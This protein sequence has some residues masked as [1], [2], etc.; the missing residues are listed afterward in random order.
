MRAQLKKRD[1]ALGV[2][3][4]FGFLTGILAAFAALALVGVTITFL[5]PSWRKSEIEDQGYSYPV[6]AAEFLLMIAPFGLL[7]LVRFSWIERRLKSKLEARREKWRVEV[8][9]AQVSYRNTW[10]KWKKAFDG[11][12]EA[13][14]RRRAAATLFDPILLRS[15]CERLDVVGGTEAGWASLLATFGSSALAGGAGIVVLDLSEW[16]V[17]HGLADLAAQEDH[18]VRRWE[19]P[20]D[21]PR[22]MSLDALGADEVADLLAEAVHSVRGEG[23]DPA[24]RTLDADIVRTVVDRL[25][26]SFTFP[27]IA[28]GLRVLESADDEGIAA[29]LTTEEIT[30]LVAAMDRFTRSDRARDEVRHVRASV[31]L[32]AGPP[33]GPVTAE[34]EAETTTPDGDHWWSP[35]PGLRIVETS[36]RMTSSAGKDLTD[37][38]TFQV[39]LHHLRQRRPTPTGMVLVVAGVDHLGRAAL[40]ELA[41]Y[42]TRAKARLVYLHHGLDDEVE[43]LIG[44]PGSATVVMQLGNAREA[45][46]A[47]RFIGRGYKFV[48]S[49]LTVQVGRSLTKGSAESVGGQEGWSYTHAAGTESSSHNWSRSWQTTHNLAVADSVSHGAT[50]QRVYE[51]AVEPTRIQS[52][53]GT[54][55]F[56]IDTVEGNRLTRSGDC[57]PGLASLRNTSAVPR[58]ARPAAVSERARTGDHGYRVSRGRQVTE[59]GG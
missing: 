22:L 25:G 5:V 1:V 10:A 53:P 33:I 19:L 54:A 50:V 46:A 16:G 37:R 8:F 49:Q 38:V 20:A 43:K 44:S 47:A 17:A 12:E 56:L 28:A 23:A 55:F 51:F 32:L 42:A 21:L 4:L 29:L 34:N 18:Q 3:G 57:N 27:R 11:H 45:E 13:E 7:C 36:A 24:M 48:F 15:P 31:Q 39:V 59:P 35:G 40:R 58:S 52:L 26:G 14:R 41:R 9:N 2:F 30:G 6:L